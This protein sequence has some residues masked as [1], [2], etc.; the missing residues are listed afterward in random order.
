M[1][2]DKYVYGGVNLCLQVSLRLELTTLQLK[3]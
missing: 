1:D 2:S 3:L